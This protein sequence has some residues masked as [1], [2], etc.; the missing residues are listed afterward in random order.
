MKQ[1][2]LTRDGL[3]VTCQLLITNE[4]R[5]INLIATK[6]G[7]NQ[8]EVEDLIEEQ[9]PNII[10]LKNHSRISLLFPIHSTIKN[11][12]E[13]L[14]LNLL[15]TNNEVIIITNKDD[16]IIN[17]AFNELRNISFDGVNSVVKHLIDSL[18]EQSIDLLDKVEDY[19]HNK[20][21][22]I[23]ENK[24]NKRLLIRMYEIKEKLYQIT[25][26]FKGN[27]EVIQELIEG[28]IH[29]IHLEEH[30]EDRIL[31]LYDLAEYLNEV[32]QS[33]IDTYLSLM[34]HRLNEQM[35]KLTIIGSILVI[36]AIISGFFGMNV[37]LPS[38]S[39]WGI[40]GLSAVLSIITYL[41]LK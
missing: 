17:K 1:I 23:L 15:V 30:H 25:K 28:K 22:K 35:Y 41:L 10:N 18:T 14:Q 40:V 16:E 37:T 26:A 3:S 21:K 11:N 38:L 7:M 4:T 33:N 34:S 6:L 29:S 8:E 9:R 13:L 36:P 5:D 20:E 24:K 27:I 12:S 39:F 19:L 31:Y 32:V 2:T